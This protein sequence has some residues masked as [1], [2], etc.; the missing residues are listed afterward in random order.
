[1]RTKQAAGAAERV[2]HVAAC[3]E[4]NG[5]EGGSDDTAGAGR[6]GARNQ[7]RTPAEN[8]EKAA[9]CFFQLLAAPGSP[10]CPSVLC[11]VHPFLG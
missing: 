5:L 6:R 11:T 8:A 9:G 10:S 1:M 3:R 2:T 4:Q 7:T